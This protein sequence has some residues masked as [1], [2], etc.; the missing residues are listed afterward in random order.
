ME[1]CKGGVTFN[2]EDL[3]NYAFEPLLTGHPAQ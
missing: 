3:D 2:F 1:I